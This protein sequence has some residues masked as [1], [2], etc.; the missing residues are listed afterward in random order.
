MFLYR[1]W[2]RGHPSLLKTVWGRASGS[3]VVP[4]APVSS[5]FT[6]TVMHPRTHTLKKLINSCSTGNCALNL[7]LLSP[8][9]IP[10]SN[11]RCPLGA[12]RHWRSAHWIVLLKLSIIQLNPPCHVFRQK[13]CSSYVWVSCRKTLRSNK[14]CNLWFQLQHRGC[15]LYPGWQ[16]ESNLCLKAQQL[17][18]WLMHLSIQR[19]LEPIGFSDLV[20]MNLLPLVGRGYLCDPANQGWLIAE[21][22]VWW[23]IENLS[24]GLFTT[25]I[26]LHA[27]QVINL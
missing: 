15:R 8:P 14:T 6:L 18:L 17:G 27:Y 19:T 16:S 7:F 22:W 5:R 10:G 25:Y 9:F 23:V 12:C 26:Y 21:Q 2:R 11:H 1:S 24:D 3:S 4:T 20:R 13:L